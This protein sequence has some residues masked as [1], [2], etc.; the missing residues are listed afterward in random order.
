[1]PVRLTVHLLVGLWIGPAV[2]RGK[3]CQI[4]QAGLQNSAAHPVKVVQIR[5]L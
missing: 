3:F 5:L 2:F 4:T 1:L